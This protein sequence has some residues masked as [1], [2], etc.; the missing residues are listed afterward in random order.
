MKE[1]CNG[2]VDFPPPS[3][4]TSHVNSCCEKNDHFNFRFN[5]IFVSKNKISDLITSSSIRSG[6]MASLRDVDDC[7]L[8]SF[9]RS[10]VNRRSGGALHEDGARIG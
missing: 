1:N 8:A 2:C 10:P 5:G 7:T 9:L 4:D 3:T 6:E